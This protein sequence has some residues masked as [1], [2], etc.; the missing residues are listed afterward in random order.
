MNTDFKTGASAPAAVARAQQP[1]LGCRRVRWFALTTIV[2]AGCFAVPLWQLCRYA[3]A[4]ELF[5]YILMV[6]LLSIFFAWS[7]RQHLAFD[8]KP[9]WG[10]S[11]FPLIVG[12]GVL[13]GVSWARQQGWSPLLE[14]YLATMTFA[15]LS[16]F[17]S[18]CFFFLGR[19]TLRPLSFS[20]FLLFFMIP[21]P[22]ILQEALTGFLQ[23]RSADVAQMLFAV[24]GMPLLRHDTVFFLP[25]FQLE[26]APECSG[27]HS[28]VVLLLT[29]LVAG[30][31]CLRSPWRRALLAFSV[32]P[33]ALLRNGF[34]IFTIGQLCVNVSPD[35]INSYIHRKGGPIFF[36]LSLIPFFLILLVLWRSEKTR[37]SPPESG[38]RAQPVSP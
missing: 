15:F 33:L 27:I 8:S 37:Q 11:M 35:M 16:L 25:G 7:Q 6:P 2:L 3:W 32:I 23:H 14:D 38:L 31:V 28:T 19:K 18:V 21:F 22:A 34:R 13:A 12:G 17:V 10:L 5:S 30:Y 36:V 9:V 29:S 4:S 20:L 24:S 1:F 26:V